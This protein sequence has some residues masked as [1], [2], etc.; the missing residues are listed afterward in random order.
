MRPP[1]PRFRPDL[2]EPRTATAIGRW[3]GISVAVCFATGLWSH[4]N[5]HPPSWLD[6]PA[7]PAWGYRLTQGLHVATGLA[8]VPL[9]LAKLWVVYP[10]LF[11]WPAVRSVRHALE[12]LSVAVLVAAVTF[13][14]VT[15]VINIAQWY[16]WRFNFTATHYAMAWV[17]IGSIALHLA[18]KLPLTRGRAAEPEPAAAAASR[19]RLL[20]TAFGTA[21]AVTVL[22][23]GQTLRPLERLAC[24]P[25]AG[26]RSAR[27]G[28]R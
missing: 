12:R 16:P 21:G 9:L 17:A 22:S 24:S 4:L 5:Q 7:A 6:L 13:Q 23:V 1:L 10:R 25:R 11:A 19:R 15:G 28:C 26:R 18:V 27:R 3:L 14:L 2:H 20:A 8:C